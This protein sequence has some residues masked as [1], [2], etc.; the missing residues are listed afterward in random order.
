MTQ[1]IIP[2]MN[3]SWITELDNQQLVDLFR[4]TI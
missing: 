4:L 2:D 1:E 3:E